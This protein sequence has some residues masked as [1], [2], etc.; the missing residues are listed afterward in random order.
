[1]TSPH[2]PR[3]TEPVAAHETRLFLLGDEGRVQPLAHERYVA[4]VRSQATAPEWAGR[5]FILVDWYVRLAGSRAQAVVNET[6]SWLVFDAAGRLD[7]PA[8]LGIAAPALPA[9]AQWAQIRKLVFGGAPPANRRS[10]AAAR[11]LSAAE[12]ARRLAAEGPNLLPGSAPKSRLAIVRTVVTEPMFLM[13][14]A[15]GGIYLALG[16]PAEALFLLGFVFVVI[17]ITLAQERKT[18][19]ALESLRELSAPRALV[20]RDGQEQRIPGADVVRGDVLVLHEGDRIAADA[21]L[22]RGPAGSGRI[23]ADRRIGAGGQD[24]RRRLC[25]PAP[26]SPGASAWPR[27]RPRPAPPPS[28]ASAPTWPPPSSRRRPCSSPRAGWCAGSARRRC[29]WPAPRCFWAGGG[30]AGRCWKACCPALRWRWPS[31]RR[32][33]RSS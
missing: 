7:L 6:C 20:M 30:T 28:A 4:L 27:C 11:G 18:Q 19:R 13:L 31:C 16:D 14:L 32:K 3:R 5:R 12:A 15:A 1:M 24:A 10:A 21:R 33:S 2:E 8:A 26:W 9:Q 17:G 29:C 25:S 22:L 23:A